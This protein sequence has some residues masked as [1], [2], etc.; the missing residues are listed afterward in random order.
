M[1]E[2]M[3]AEEFLEWMA[4]DR[5]EPFGDR[6]TD[7]NFALIRTQMANMMRSKDQPAYKLD[8]F[9]L[10]FDHDPDKPKQTPERILS[11][12]KMLAAAS[13]KKTANA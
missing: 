9:M 4:F 11:I 2:R 1:M 10:R 5:I 8:E 7:L 6:R 3:S 13:K 12:M